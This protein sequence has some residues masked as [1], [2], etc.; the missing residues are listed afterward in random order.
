VGSVEAQHA[1]GGAD[2]AAP[3]AVRDEDCEVPEG[4]AHLVLEL[5][6]AIRRE[7][8][9]LTWSGLLDGRPIVGDCVRL[10][11][12]LS[13]VRRA[14]PVPSIEADLDAPGASNGRTSRPAVVES[15]ADGS[16]ILVRPIEPTDEHQLERAFGRLGALSRYE[17]FRRRT[18][19][20]TPS[21]SLGRPMP[22]TT[23]TRPSSRS[24]RQPATGSGSRAMCATPMTP[25]GRRSLARSPTR[26][27]GAGSARQWSSV[28]ARAQE[29]GIERFTAHLLVGNERARRL[30]ARVADETSE[31]RYGEVVEITARLR[32]AR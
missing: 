8:F 5:R 10:A 4:D 32:A 28:A 14:V 19:E 26:G 24:T 20:L 12:N 13:L 30:L 16:Q 18:D 2:D 27:R 25:S 31:S 21:S 15:L 6:G 23:P 17:R 9:R 29:V 11:I 7:D 1:L 3:E 22:T